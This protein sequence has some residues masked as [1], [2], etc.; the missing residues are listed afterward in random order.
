[1]AEDADSPSSVGDDDIIQPAEAS[2]EG[3]AD[4]HTGAP[5]HDR[6]R[7]EVRLAVI[8]GAIAVVVLAGIA[9]W[10]SYGAWRCHESD[11]QRELF[12]RVARQSAHDMTTISH[13]QVD[14]DV[15]RIL[16]TSVGQFH[17]EFAQR[18][19]PFIEHI[20]QE[21]STSQGT[22]VEAGLES[23]GSDS[24][25]ALVTVSVKLTKADNGEA[26]LDGFRLRIGMQRVGAGAKVSEVE[27]VQ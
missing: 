25:R 27:Y 5:N 23:V 2:P 3:A 20:K 18:K 12:L 11:Q 14:S 17:D 4:Q 24:A 21:Q 8:V 7:P 6:S 10:T 13:T 26:K 22:V 19:Q 16:D 15:Q 1:M 9:G